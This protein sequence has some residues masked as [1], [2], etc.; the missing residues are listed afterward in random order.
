MKRVIKFIIALLLGGIVGFIC[1]FVGS[2]VIA[3]TVATCLGEGESCV[4]SFP[5]YMSV[6]VRIFSNSGPVWIILWTFIF[7]KVLSR[8]IR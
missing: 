1:F 7:Y 2:L 5:F 8:F 4:R 6:L 3:S